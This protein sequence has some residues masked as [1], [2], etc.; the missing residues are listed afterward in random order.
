[1]NQYQQYIRNNFKPKAY[2]SHT[3]EPKSQKI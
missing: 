2:H 1:M 3:I